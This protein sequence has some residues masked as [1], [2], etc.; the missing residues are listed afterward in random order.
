[1]EELLKRIGATIF[2]HILPNEYDWVTGR[3]RHHI[4]YRDFIEIMNNIANE[5][6]IRCKPDK[7]S[8]QCVMAVVTS[9][10]YGLAGGDDTHR[11]FTIIG[12][13]G[14]IINVKGCDASQKI[15]IFIQHPNG[16]IACEEPSPRK[17][18]EQIRQVRYLQ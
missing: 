11:D 3:D 7:S 14:R 5:K 6:S 18:M 9:Q 16:Q 8:S 15:K 1:M 2:K 12:T 17:V 10:M 13:D 4:D